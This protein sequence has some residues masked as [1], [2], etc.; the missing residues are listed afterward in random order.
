MSRSDVPVP[1]CVV[2]SS[3]GRI[4]VLW[5]VQGFSAADA[6]AS[7]EAP[8]AG[9]R[10]RPRGDGR[11][12]D[13]AGAGL[14]EPQVLAAATRQ[15]RVRC[16]RACSTPGDFPEPPDARTPQRPVTPPAS[17][18]DT[19]SSP[20]V[21]ARARRYLAAVPPAVAGQGGDLR[22]FRLCCRLVRGFA[23]DAGR[24]AGLAG[25]VERPLRAAVDRARVDCDKL[26][27]AR[28][29]GREPVGGLLRAPP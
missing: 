19:A 23:L 6:R 24:G 17:R 18:S 20:D 13:D 7:A 8:R 5:R 15:R 9:T 3:P 28:R 22:T 25:R 29:Y 12:A 1:S 10:R 27:H 11:L 16:R 2:H 21:M 14:P 26:E 4:Q